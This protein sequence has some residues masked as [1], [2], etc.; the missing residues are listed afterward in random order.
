MRP[1]FTLLLFAAALFVACSQNESTLPYQKLSDSQ[2]EIFR[3]AI[4][5]RKAQPSWKKTNSRQ[6]KSLGI[7]I[8]QDENEFDAIVTSKGFQR[9]GG[10]SHGTPYSCASD[11]CACSES[12]SISYVR[13]TNVSKSFETIALQFGP[14]TFD[15]VCRSGL[16]NISPVDFYEKT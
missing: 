9:V 1:K 14:R 2:A 10:Q 15:G 16:F 6:Q 8:G 7:S 4:Y 11:P 13:T 5:S 3:Q 12:R